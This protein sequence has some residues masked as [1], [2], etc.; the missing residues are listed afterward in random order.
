M[1]GGAKESHITRGQEAPGSHSPDI[2]GLVSIEK[3]N[4]TGGSNTWQARSSHNRPCPQA[5]CSRQ[6]SA[7]P[8]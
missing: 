8:S 2:I 1:G 7:P 6:F 3:N 4:K 5:S